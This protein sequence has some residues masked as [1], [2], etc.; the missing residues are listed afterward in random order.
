VLKHADPEATIVDLPLSRDL[1]LE[2]EPEYEWGAE[3]DELVLL[4]HEVREM[5]RELGQA[6]ESLDQALKL[7]RRRDRLHSMLRAK[8]Q[9]MTRGLRISRA[10]L[11]LMVAVFT[12]VGVIAGAGVAAA[13]IRILGDSAFATIASAFFGFAVALGGWLAASLAAIVLETADS[14]RDLP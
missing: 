14:V 10:I 13:G 2:E 7:V 1:A 8:R 3:V 4:K 6:R 9:D 12:L 5:R 11:R